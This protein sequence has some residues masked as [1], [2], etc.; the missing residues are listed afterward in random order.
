MTTA[1]WKQL[2][3]GMD[4]L[5]PAP[6]YIRRETGRSHTAYMDETYE[7]ATR[8][9]ADTKISYRPHAKAPG[10][11]SH[12]RYEEYSSAKT[13][14]E[15]LV[16][17]S[18]P[19]DWCWDYERGF[20]KVEGPV[21]E[22]PI[23]ISKVVDDST[24]TEVDWAIIRWY[25]R[26][27]AKKHGL[28]YR[29][30]TVGKGGGETLIMR[31]HRLVAK[32][33][34]KKRLEA[35]EQ[36]GRKITEDEVRQTLSE[37][38]YAKN[39]Y[40]QNVMQDGQEWVWSDTMGLLRDRIGDIHLTPSTHGYPEV[41]QLINKYLSDRLPPE[42]ANF[43]WTSLNL[44]CNYAA[45]LHRDGNNFGPSFIKAFGEFSGG[46]LNYWPED[47]RK[48][49]KLEDLKDKDKVQFDLK[50]ELA[51]FNGNC[52]HSVVPFEGNRFSVVYFTVG[53]YALAPQ[54]CKDGLAALGFSCPADDEDR[55]ALLRPPRGYGAAS[56]LAITTP[57]KGGPPTHRLWRVAEL[58]AAPSPQPR[59]KAHGGVTPEAVLKAAK[60][61]PAKGK[62]RA[63][64]RA[65]E[66]E[67]P[68][69]KAAKGNVAKASGGA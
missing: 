63:A 15:A 17:G 52:G 35:A 38:A 43:K 40:R 13:V 10:T 23:D 56:G 64:A 22:E 53:C 14:G 18:W 6:P 60:M 9:T 33:E 25:Q 59:P 69:A 7:I 51:L 32:R 8:W 45:K 3:V 30:L 48:A 27:L 2:Q 61:P 20:L 16:L 44:N 49:D 31:A 12:M 67:N 21:R 37:W 42:V 57:A 34:A 36:E 11:K 39:I 47:D 41:V 62:K 50:N 65:A 5:W 4:E 19:A 24:L 54:Q 28:D 55:H 26:E 66:E 68:D 1:E 58:D 29:D 46:T